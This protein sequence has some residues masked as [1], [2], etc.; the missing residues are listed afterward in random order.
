MARPPAKTCAA[1][2][3]RMEYRRRRDRSWDEV[4]YCSRACRRR[5]VNAVDRA[6]E[7]SILELLDGRRR[8][9]SICPSEAARG[10]APDDW[11]RLMEP[12]RRAARRL[13]HRGR[14]EVLQRGRPVDPSSFRGPIRLQLAARRPKGG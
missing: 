4:R 3:R 12:A 10:V 14:V 13:A 7:A 5:R 11:R 6:L 2:G 1:C 8:G 9:A